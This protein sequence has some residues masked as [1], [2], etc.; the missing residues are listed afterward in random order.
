[1]EN[2]TELMSFVAASLASLSVLQEREKDSKMQEVISSL[3]SCDLPKFSNLAIYS[4]RTSKEFCPT[5]G[6]TTF[7]KILQTLDAVGFDVEWQLLNSKDYGVSQNRERVF[8]VG[9]LR[10]KRTRQIFPL[11]GDAG[12]NPCKLQELTTN[13]KQGMRVYSPSGLSVTLSSQGGGLGAKTGLYGFIDLTKNG[14]KITQNARTL[15]ARYDKG[16]TNRKGETSG[17]AVYPVLTPD[18]VNKRQNGRRFKNDGD[19]MFT[20]TAQD[21][22]GIVIRKENIRIRKLTP[23]ETFRL[24]GLPDEH[25]YNARAAGLSDTQLYKQA[26]NAVT[27]PVIYEIAKRLEVIE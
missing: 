10:G 1:M 9:H 11:I 8:I 15:Q 21:R 26:G 3:K 18:R 12:E 24:Q 22:H 14:A 7:T 13:S 23:L 20:L 5:G 4:L 16:V 6:G 19:P 17:I 27:V 2:K 25:Y